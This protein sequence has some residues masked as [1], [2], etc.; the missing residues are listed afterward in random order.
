MDANKD[1]A[2]RCVSMA[3]ARLSAGQTELARRYVMKAVRLYPGVSIAGLESLVC[4]SRSQSRERASTVNRDC[5]SSQNVSNP[6]PPEHSEAVFTRAQA[7]AVR[8]V[9]ACKDYYE[10]L[11]VTKDSSEDVIRRSYKSLALKFHPDKNRAPGATE[12]FKKIGTALSVL[13]DPEKRRRYD[14]YGTEEEQV[15]R[16][17]RVHRHGDPFFQYDGDVFT[18]F[19]N[20][21]FP[22]SQVYRGHHQRPHSRESERE[23]AS[24]VIE[25]TT[26]SLSSRFRLRTCGGAEVGSVLS[27][28]VKPSLFRCIPIAN[29]LC[30]VHH[31]LFI[32]PAYAPTDCSSESAKDSFYDAIGA[33]LQQGR[34]S[35]IA[36]VSGDMN[37]Q[38]PKWLL[39][40]QQSRTFVP[41]DTVLRAAIQ[42]A[43]CNLQS[44]ILASNRWTVN[45]ELP[46]ASEVSAHNLQLKRHRAVGPDDLPTA[47][48]K[49]GGGFLS[50]CLSSLCG[51][52]WEIGT[53]PDNWD[54]WIVV[55]V[56]KKGTC[57]ECSNHRGVNLAPIVT[58][59]LVLL[60]LHPLT[61]ACDTLTREHQ[62]GF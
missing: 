43:T 39:D 47:L 57:S 4:N 9:L 54:E 29:R 5:D 56:F 25:L 1:E 50:Q 6:P 27:G 61:L 3:R 60:I 32:V 35:D 24:T 52:I 30:A 31:T 7:E 46:S 22:F 14:Q 58:R 59:L 41:L 17:T 44:R 18:M 36:L 62:A 48:F 12:A 53:F 23:D 2:L 11:G 13:T 55:P 37:A 38:G 15:P 26:H 16:I 40:M 8:K 21:G 34:S 10:L 33:F 19:F 45:M 28:R 42:L 49:D 20:G 51:S